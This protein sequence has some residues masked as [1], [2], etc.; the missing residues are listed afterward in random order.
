MAPSPFRIL[1]VILLTSMLTLA[2]GAEAEQAKL[3]LEVSNAAAATCLKAKETLPQIPAIRRTPDTV[4]DMSNI[5]GT[6]VVKDEIIVSWDIQ[7]LHADKKFRL[8]LRGVCHVSSDGR[9]LKSI[10]VV[11]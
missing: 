5:T 3:P 7:N 8:A 9:T 11:E 2:T 1:P 10:K 6:Q 4:G